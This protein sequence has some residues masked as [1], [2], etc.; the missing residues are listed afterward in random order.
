MLRKQLFFNACGDA[1]RYA[2][3]NRCNKARSS[4]SIATHVVYQWH[5]KSAEVAM[6]CVLWGV[7]QREGTRATLAQFCH[8]NDVCSLESIA[9][10]PS[11]PRMLTRQRG[12]NDVRSSKSIATLYLYHLLGRVLVLQWCVFFGEYCNLNA[13]EHG[14]RFTDGCNNVCSLG[15]IAT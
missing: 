9:T 14:R 6:M 1:V 13:I 4:R 8:C 3:R 2:M 10:W 15:S 11:V 12:C 5:L 7:L